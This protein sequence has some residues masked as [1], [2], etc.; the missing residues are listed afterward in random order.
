M[1]RPASEVVATAP[2]AAPAARVKLNGIENLQP[3]FRARLLE[4]LAS[5][6]SR[7]GPWAG[8][9]DGASITLEIGTHG[10]FAAKAA[11]G[12]SRAGDAADAEL[13][14]LARSLALP[15]AVTAP[16]AA[17][18]PVAASA[19][20]DAAD[21]RALEDAV[22]RIAWGGDRRRGVARLELGGSYAGTVVT[23][24]GEGRE[25]ALRLEVPRGASVNRLPERLVERLEARGL[26]VTAVEVT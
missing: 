17:P 15:A 20:P 23:I 24:R 6:P 1:V 18:L 8:C 7:L 25:V 3:G 13:D 26:T 16:P 5:C 22:R 2:G 19:T 9:L 21:T 14:P 11:R 4:A 12:A 10:R